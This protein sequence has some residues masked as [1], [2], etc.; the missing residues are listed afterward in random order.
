MKVGE[1]LLLADQA[2]LH[3]GGDRISYKRYF[4]FLLIACRFFVM[5]T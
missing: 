2:D 5:K 3:T 4:S 1:P